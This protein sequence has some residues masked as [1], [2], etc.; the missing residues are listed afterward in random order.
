MYHTRTCEQLIERTAASFPCIAIY[1]PRQV[2]KSTTIHHLFRNFCPMVT[3]DDRSDRD[4]A[5][6][7]PR[8]FLE[9]YGWPLVIDEIQKAPLLLDEI[10]KQIDA[11]RLK[12]MDEGKPQKL[13]YILTGSS[14]FTLEQ[15]I[16]DSLAGRCGIIEMASFSLCETLGVPASPF[17]PDIASLLKKERETPVPYQ[18]KQ[19]IFHRIFHGGMPDIATGT[20]QRDIYF[21]SYVDTYI[22]KDVR[23]LLNASN[24]TAFRTFLEIVALRT[25]QEL[26]YEEIAVQTGIDVRTCKRW[27]SI[28][29]SSGII[30][31]L[32]PFM[33]N[34]SNRVIKAPKLYFMDTGL[35]AY[36]C[37]WPTAEMLGKGV[38]SGAFFET[39]VVSEI[40][41]NLQAFGKDVDST[42]FYYRDKDQKEID[43]L[44]LSENG[45]YPIEIKEGSYPK[46]AARKFSALSKYP[47]P[48]QNGLVINPC[49]KMRPLGDSAW[50]YPV[51]RIG[52]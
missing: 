46:K 24:E 14:R 25:A 49:D 44:Y 21:K 19:D 51:Y 27:L 50:F 7:N 28:L 36:L 43:L 6:T 40:V 52:T 42:L 16:T 1:G 48:V 31:L 30:H 45:L 4:L 39:F 29:V 26:H 3:L 20:A 22:E 41:K 35:C 12:W 9:A 13:M 15:G 38:M 8:Q 37:K 11:Q 23:T 5:L 34:L 17:T 33:A 2:G 10:K 18:N 47:Q 32:R